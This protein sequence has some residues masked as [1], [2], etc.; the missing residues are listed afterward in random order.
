V[1]EV[2]LLITIDSLGELAL[3]NRTQSYSP[4]NYT[5]SFRPKKKV[6]NIQLL[7]EN[8][9]FPTPFSLN[10]KVSDKSTPDIDIRRNDSDIRSETSPLT[11]A[12]TFR[13]DN[14]DH[15][16]PIKQR[17]N[18][19]LHTENVYLYPSVFVGQ[20]Q[21]GFTASK[22]ID[23][24]DLIKETGELHKEVRA[25]DKFTMRSSTFT[26]ANRSASYCN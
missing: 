19:A 20:D 21:N 25:L 4:V 6:M 26:S 22:A 15:E 17:Q 2:Y 3:I 9:P 14:V 8:S 24:K 16:T 1:K 11:K 7:N 13:K 5:D 10:D 12:F 23:F 18:V